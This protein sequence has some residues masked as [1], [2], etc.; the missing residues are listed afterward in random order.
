MLISGYYRGGL[1]DHTNVLSTIRSESFAYEVTFVRC[2]NTSGATS[3]RYRWLYF[4]MLERVQECFAKGLVRRHFISTRTL[5]PRKYV[6]CTENSFL[7]TLRGRFQVDL[8]RSLLVV[9]VTA[10]ERKITHIGN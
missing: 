6:G 8:R 1:W 10:Q 2:K 9:M 4:T 5:L 3:K 7:S